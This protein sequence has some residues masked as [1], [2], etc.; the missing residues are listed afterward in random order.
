MAARTLEY[1]NKIEQ[2]P[3]D[4]ESEAIVQTIRDYFN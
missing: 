3:Q 4:Q 1:R 2:L